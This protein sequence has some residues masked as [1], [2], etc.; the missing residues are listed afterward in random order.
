MVHSVIKKETSRLFVQKAHHFYFNMLVGEVGWSWIM[1]LDWLDT[2]LFTT[3]VSMR[4]SLKW[5][6]IRW[7]NTYASELNAKSVSVGPKQR[8]RPLVVVRRA[9]L[10]VRPRITPQF[11][12]QMF[13][14]LA[15]LF[16]YKKYTILNH[17][18]TENLFYFTLDT[19]GCSL[20]WPMALRRMTRR[21][22]DILRNT[23]CR[24][25]HP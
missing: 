23:N 16:I 13:W 12:I 15:Y 4:I 18:Y 25:V 17:Y 21:P 10:A 11:S 22:M 6:H 19:T 20:V 3:R 9:H 1:L 5:H 24:M 2:V 14:N 7:Q 8:W